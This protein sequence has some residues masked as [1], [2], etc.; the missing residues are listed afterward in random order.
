MVGLAPIR[1]TPHMPDVVAPVWITWKVFT[2]AGAA[3]IAGYPHRLRLIR[4]ADEVRVELLL[5]PHDV[6]DFEP[7]GEGCCAPLT[8]VPPDPN[9]T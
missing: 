1:Y 2:A 6:A 7:V 4:V 9:A 5:L 8:A 3:I